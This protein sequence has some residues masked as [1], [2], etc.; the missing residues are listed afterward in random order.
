MLTLLQKTSFFD[1]PL[2]FFFSKIFR[3]ELEWTTLCSYISVI[4][5]SKATDE[6]VVKKI[7]LEATG[8]LSREEESFLLHKN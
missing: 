6:K 4:H 8:F 3:S 7:F 1:L 2:F 5:F